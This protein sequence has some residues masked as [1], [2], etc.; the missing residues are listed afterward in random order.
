M[1]K[2]VIKPFHNTMN[3]IKFNFLLINFFQLSVGGF[4]ETKEGTICD[5]YRNNA[6]MVKD[7]LE[8]GRI[9]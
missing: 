8:E 3:R 5:V 4:L 1:V 7:F 9:R 2:R 6:R